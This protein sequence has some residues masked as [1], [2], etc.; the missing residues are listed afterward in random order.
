MISYDVKFF[1]VRTSVS[2]HPL[3]NKG[4]RVAKLVPHRKGK[5][6]TPLLSEA[7]EQ[8]ENGAAG[9]LVSL[10]EHDVR[11]RLT[12]SQ[13]EPLGILR[14]KSKEGSRPLWLHP[15]NAEKEQKNARC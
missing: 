14:G 8:I 7:I 1:H 11:V 5:F 2:F 15:A 10:Q 4:K 13:R 9:C 6:K 3:G 12:R